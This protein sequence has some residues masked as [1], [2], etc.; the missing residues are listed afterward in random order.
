[1][2]SSQKLIYYTIINKSNVQSTETCIKIQNLQTN[3]LF[4]ACV[5]ISYLF[6]GACH[7]YYEKS[8]N[9]KLCLK[10]I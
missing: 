5:L 4:I 6:E 8:D 9:N 1:M 10:Y 3:I 2:H 7:V